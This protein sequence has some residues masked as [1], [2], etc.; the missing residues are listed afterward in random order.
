[1]ST[2]GQCEKESL[3]KISEFSITQLT[4]KLLS[5]EQKVGKIFQSKEN[6]S[7]QKGRQVVQRLCTCQLVGK[8]G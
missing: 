5:E 2:T 4:T 8:G 7:L 6:A 1:M 3:K